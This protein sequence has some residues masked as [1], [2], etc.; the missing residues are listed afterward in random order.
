MCEGKNQTL[1]WNNSL[2]WTKMLK[3]KERIKWKMWIKYERNWFESKE[4]RENEAEL[5]ETLRKLSLGGGVLMIEF[6][7]DSSRFY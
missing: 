4:W 7:E 6:F 3:W 5:Q 1:E 2:T